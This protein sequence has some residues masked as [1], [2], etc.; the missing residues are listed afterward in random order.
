MY[1]GFSHIYHLVIPPQSFEVNNI[2]I[3]LTNIY[4]VLTVHWALF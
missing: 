1:K 2:G 3:Y 4:V